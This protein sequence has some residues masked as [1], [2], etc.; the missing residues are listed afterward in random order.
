MIKK[1]L[2]FILFYNISY[3]QSF[4]ILDDETLEF[5]ENVNYNLFLNKTKIYSNV[6][7]IEGQT[8]LP[9]QIVYDSISFH[10]LNYN[11]LGLRKESIS[12]TILLSKKIITLDEVVISSNNIKEI[13]LGE[14]NRFIKRYSSSF[15]KT[16]K[17]GCVFHNQTS[18][19]LFLKKVGFYVEKVKYKT[20][21]K[22]NFYKFK[23]S[24]VEIGHQK[25]IINELIFA[26]DTL[27]LEPTQ[28][29][30]ITA[31]LTSNY[32]LE[33]NESIFVDIQLINYY[34]NNENIIQPNIE[35]E[36]KLKFQLSNKTNYY[37]KMVNHSTGE[38]TLDYVNINAMINYDFANR[39]FKKPH[40]S[41]LVT[42][43]MILYTTINP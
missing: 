15:L 43:V 17:F 10:S 36:T 21:Y 16:P 2:F 22:I 4:I 28:K 1:I 9:K 26:T 27:F 13:T 18:T 35:D 34:D 3:S 23:Q 37:S 20:A 32:R 24:P 11:I 41:N 30:Q 12:Q 42:P 14:K 38:Y 8:T 19:D 31:I 33:K 5:I 25:K 40:K 7:N 6:C 39:F 29:N